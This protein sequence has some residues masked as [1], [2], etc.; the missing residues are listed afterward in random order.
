MK[1][2]LLCLLFGLGVP[3]LSFATDLMDIYQQALENDPIFKQA[4]SIYMSNTEAV[5]IARA[6]LYPQL[7]ISALAAR[8]VTQVAAASSRLATTYNSNQWQV[9]ASQA[10]FNYKAW[11]QVQRAKASVKAAQASFNDSAQDLIVRTASA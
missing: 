8:N 7:T 9:N 6:A 11:A 2:K 1:R 10:L 4:Y 5:P 3:A